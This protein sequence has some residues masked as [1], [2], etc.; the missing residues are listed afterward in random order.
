MIILFDGGMSDDPEYTV[1]S[2]KQKVLGRFPALEFYINSIGTIYTAGHVNNMYNRKRKFQIQKD[3]IVEVKQ[4]FSYVG[5]KGKT[6][7]EIILYKEKEG[8]DI[9]VAKLPKD[10]EIEILLT[11]S[12]TTNY[13]IDLYYLVK[14]DFGLVGWLRLTNEDV[15]GRVLKELYYKGD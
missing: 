2:N 8:S 6:L 11:E 7:K 12:N 14:T 10:Y 5:L 15:F 1:L 3:T 4:P 13:Q 9:Y